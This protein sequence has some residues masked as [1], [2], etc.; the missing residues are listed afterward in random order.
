M[1]PTRRQRIVELLR[2]RQRTPSGLAE[3]VDA[4]VEAVHDDL[5]HVAESLEGTEER[6]LV[7]PPECRE[8]GFDGFH[9]KI[10]PS[11]CPECKSEHLGEAVFVV[12][13]V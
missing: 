1:M 7:A 3:D 6:L 9:D 11:K 5:E 12:E 13:E 4:S 10:A 2:Q 8:C